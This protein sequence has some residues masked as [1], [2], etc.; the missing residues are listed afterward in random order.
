[1]VQL[2]VDDAERFCIYLLND[3]N[4]NGATVMLAPA[5]GFYATAG[6]GKQEVRAAYVLE[7]PKLRQA[8]EI[9]RAALAA[10]PGRRA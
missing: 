6:L 3:F 7:E 2:P 5:D 4:V 9:L 8:C 10:Y 1:V